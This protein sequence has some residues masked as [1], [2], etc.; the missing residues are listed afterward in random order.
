[1][2]IVYLYNKCFYW[3]V[4]L[5]NQVSQISES[6]F[7]RL[8]RH[9]RR[10]LSKNLDNQIYRFR[11][12][13]HRF[14]YPLKINS[15]LIFLFFIKWSLINIFQYK[16]SIFIVAKNH[17]FISIKQQIIFRTNKPFF[18]YY[19]KDWKQTELSSSFL[20]HFQKSFEFILLQVG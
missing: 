7:S 2:E 20:Q 11:Q 8:H 10:W 4:Q 19:L 1:M 3:S 12:Y 14:D 5:H 16:I 17:P 13:Y 15:L 9:S 6:I 18:K